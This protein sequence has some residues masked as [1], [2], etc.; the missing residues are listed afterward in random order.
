MGVFRLDGIIVTHYDTDHVGGVPYLLTRI[1]A[2]S[3]YLPKAGAEETVASEVIAALDTVLWVED[4]LRWTFGKASIQLF[5]P[6]TLEFGNE[7]SVCILFRMENCDILITGDRSREGELRLLQRTQ[8]PELELLIAGHHGSK[9]ATS[10]SLLSQTSPEY[11]FISAG[12][13][14]RYGHPSEEVL[15]RLERH[16]CTVY[17]TDRHGDLIFRR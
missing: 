1:D 13:N 15:E 4:D 12:E 16:G 2:D 5:A 14:N 3:V 11:V 9:N 7:S 6:E 8:L 10:D 17:R